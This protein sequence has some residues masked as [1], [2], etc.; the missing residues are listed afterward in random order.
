MAQASTLH[1]FDIEL[2]DVDRGVYE[3]LALRLARHP[4]ESEE[5]FL[6]R[7]LAYCLEYTEG[8]SF[9]QGLSSPDDPTLAIRDLTGQLC[10]WID[11]GAP[12]ARRLHKAS[13]AAPRVVIYT[14]KDP[15]VL[16]RQLQGEK[17]HRAEAIEL[18]SIDRD[19]VKAVA[20]RL[21]RRTAMALSISEGRLY[22]TIGDESW[23]GVV[24]PYA[25]A[26]R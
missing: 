15:V 23:S 16:L 20:A 6:T 10:A 11:V 5:Y 1:N 3:T 17:I 12:D 19:M 24:T 14:H 22:L 25:L 21:Q 8:L 4:S 13:K 2:S 9:G 18:R 7:V 26:G